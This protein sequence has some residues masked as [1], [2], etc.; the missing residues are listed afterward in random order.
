MSQFLSNM[1][2]READKSERAV[3][4]RPSSK[5]DRWQLAFFN[6]LGELIG[7]EPSITHNERDVA[8]ATIILLHCSI[9]SSTVTDVSGRKNGYTAQAFLVSPLRSNDGPCQRYLARVAVQRAERRVI[10]IRIH[11]QLVLRMDRDLRHSQPSQ[12]KS[13]GIRDV[14]FKNFTYPWYPSFSKSDFS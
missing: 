5:R 10:R 9:S 13:S 7:N 3:L 11:R 12:N 2:Y 1:R 4:W 6:R 14:D 8:L